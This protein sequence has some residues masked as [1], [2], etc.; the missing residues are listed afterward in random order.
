MKVTGKRVPGGGIYRCSHPEAGTCLF[1][2]RKFKA[3]MPGGRWGAEGQLEE[4]AGSRAGEPPEP[5]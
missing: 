3:T 4:P 2:L 5:C 1:C